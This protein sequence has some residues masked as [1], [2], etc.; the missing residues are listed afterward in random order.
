MKKK[1]KTKTIESGVAPL[2]KYCLKVTHHR[3]SH[4]KVLATFVPATEGPAGLI[5][6][7]SEAVAEGRPYRLYNEQGT[8][9]MILGL[10]LDCAVEVM[11]WEH[12]V[13]QEEAQAAARAAEQRRQQLGG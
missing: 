1:R 6:A 10:N 12:F 2:V 7:L 13:K 8:P 9:N 5:D 3:S 11:L 4:T